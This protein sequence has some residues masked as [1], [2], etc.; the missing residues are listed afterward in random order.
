MAV[1]LRLSRMA[2]VVAVV[3]LLA[4]CAAHQVVPI[5][6]EPGPVDVYVDGEL[7]VRGHPE[8]LSLPVDRGHVVL[9]RRP[10]FRAEQVVVES[11]RGD[12][13]AR[14]LVPAEIAVRLSPLQSRGRRIEVELDVAVEDAPAALTP[15]NEPIDDSGAAPRESDETKR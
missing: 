15:A 6:V 3:T 9:I 8:S 4:G 1:F 13:G 5:R 10:G 11:V 7:A 2:A 14:R 12:G